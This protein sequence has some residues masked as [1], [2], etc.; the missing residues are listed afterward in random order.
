[1]ANNVIHVNVLQYTILIILLKI[2]KRNRD[3]A[4]LLIIHFGLESIT[5]LLKNRES[6]KYLKEK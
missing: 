3:L 6:E 2:W 5:E 4:V 1:M